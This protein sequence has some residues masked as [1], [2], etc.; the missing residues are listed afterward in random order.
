MILE[1][2]VLPADDGRKIKFYVRG[3]MGVSYGQFA[4]LK[5]REGMRVNGVP[6]HANHILRTG[7]RVEVAIEETGS[8]LAEPVAGEVDVRY[9]DD[10][11]MILNKPAPLACQSSSRNAAPALENFLMAKY[12][13]GFVFR[14]L[15]RLDKGTSGL[16][17]AAKNAHAYQL[18]QRTLHTGDYLRQYLAVVCGRL[19]GSGVVDAP[20][21][22]EDAATVRRV[23]DFEKGKPAVTRWESQGV[24]GEYSLVRLTL[25]TGRTHQIRVHMAHLGHPVAGDFL[26]GTELACLPG[27]FALHSAR[28]RLTHP[29]TGEVLEITSPLPEELQNLLQ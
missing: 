20:I 25:E 21:A 22:K 5:M 23:V 6:V 15:N 4:S 14:P 18:M 7:D 1:S 9:E 2:V 26:Y 19:E 16:M 28:I 27:R 3:A 29:M 12:G 11:L 8:S 10:A 17:C 13:D 24:F